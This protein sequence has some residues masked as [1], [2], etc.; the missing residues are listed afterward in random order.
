MTQTANPLKQFFRQPSLYLKLPSD[1]QFWET[2]SLELPPNKELPVLPM[3]AMDEITYRTPDALF[4]GSAVVNVIQSCIPGIKN[5]WKT[6]SVDL[7]S[8]L[9][10]IRIAT[11]NSE[12]DISSTC[13]A[14]NT[15]GEYTLNLH[16]ILGNLDKID[17]SKSVKHGD[18]ELFFKS[19]DYQTQNMLNT[20][21][22]EQ[23]RIIQ[24]IPDSGGTE[25]QK[26]AQLNIAVKEVTKLTIMAIANSIAGIRTPNAFVTEFEFIEDF[27]N[28]CDRNLFNI[29]RDHAIQMRENSELR[30]VPVV[31][32][33]CNHNY[34]QSITLDSTSFFAV[35]S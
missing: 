31:C 29:V 32:S 20:R 11:Y 26:L 21:Q 12:M 1:G 23:Q 22:F 4:N 17:Y 6:P 33:N 25:E 30:P 18:L 27:L 16:T 28:N 19:V 15:E 2:G 3:T 13:P 10:A 8:I 9:I 7:T 14:C 35:A 5:A 34:E 24:S